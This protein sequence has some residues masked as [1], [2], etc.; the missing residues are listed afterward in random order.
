MKGDATVCGVEKNKSYNKHIKKKQCKTNNNN[1]EKDDD[2]NNQID[3]NK[4]FLQLE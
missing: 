4:Y 1:S 3:N 2:N